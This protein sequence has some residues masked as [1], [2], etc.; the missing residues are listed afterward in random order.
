MREN[1]AV[2]SWAFVTASQCHVLFVLGQTERTRLPSL[3]EA[4]PH[5]CWVYE[6]KII[7]H[8]YWFLI[9]CLVLFAQENEKD[10]LLLHSDARKKKSF[11]RDFR[12]VFGIVP[13]S[14][15]FTFFHLLSSCI[16]LSFPLEVRPC[17]DAL[18]SCIGRL[19]GNS[20][21]EEASQPPKVK[22][23]G[24]GRRMDGPICRTL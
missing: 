19:C 15:G 21:A 14:C 11:T 18:I 10:V 22:W 5:C 24:R 8:L 13:I 6:W 3:R 17:D 16:L 9:S 23:W 12:N 20:S 2:Q 1:D 7:S 4:A